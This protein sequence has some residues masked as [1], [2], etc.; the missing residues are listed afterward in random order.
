MKK[1]FLLSLLAILTLTASAQ[2]N[3]YAMVIEMQ[4][5][6]KLTIGP[7][8]VKNV[9]F[10]NGELTVT[11]ETIETLV[12]SAVN[13]AKEYTDQAAA[14]LKGYIDLSREL[15][16]LKAA[17]EAADESIRAELAAKQTLIE[18]N[19]AAI[20]ALLDTKFNEL[21]KLIDSNAKDV[22]A[23]AKAI[24]DNKAAQDAA[25]IIMQ[26]NIAQNAKDNVAQGKDITNLD[27][28]IKAIKKAL[29]DDTAET[30]KAYAKSIAESNA[31][32]AKLDAQSYADTK[33]AAQSQTLM[34]AIK[35]QAEQDAKA[36]TS[37]M[38]LSIE[39]LVTTYKLASLNEIISA[40]INEAIVNL[41]QTYNQQKP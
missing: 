9:T 38:N 25:N 40:R 24:S 2:T 21:N 5:G 1:Y 17:S 31:Y 13:Q 15:A 7:N 41:I 30:L 8:E 14:N 23:N 37:A 39:N 22:L 19:D 18:T 35:D 33:D 34:Q 28:A 29:G 6:T 10:N 11:G 26:N 27:D 3:T 12:A 20:M 32:Q 4:N 36:W 16:E